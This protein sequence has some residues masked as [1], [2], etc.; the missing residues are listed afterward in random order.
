VR[1]RVQADGRVDQL[2]Q[3]GPLGVGFFLRAADDRRDARQ[4]Q[5]LLRAAAVFGQPAL[6][7]AVEGLR[8]G[9]AGPGGEDGFGR[10]G[11][12]LAPG[13][14]EPACTITG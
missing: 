1:E 6:H 8:F 11:G 13:S 5:Q 14:D 9:Q 2:L 7:V 3:L 10:S 4:D 12:Q